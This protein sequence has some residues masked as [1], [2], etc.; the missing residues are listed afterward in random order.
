M[1]PLDGWQCAA[2]IP[3]AV[4]FGS[5]VGDGIAKYLPAVTEG[6]VRG[7]QGPALFNPVDDFQQLR[8][9]DLGDGFAA[10]L[11]EDVP[12]QP[13]DDSLAMIDR[14]VGGVLGVPFPRYHLEAV[15]RPLDLDGL[16]GLAVFAGVDLLGQ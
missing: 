8:R 13:T 11:G 12:I 5:P 16:R 14:P 1:S 2:Q 9:G 7:F 15:R 6:P 4:A 3:G 10:D